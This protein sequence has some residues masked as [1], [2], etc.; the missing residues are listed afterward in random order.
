MS[1]TAIAATVFRVDATKVGISN[2]PAIY[3]EHIPKCPMVCLDD[4]GQFAFYYEHDEYRFFNRPD[5][6]PCMT[7]D[8]YLVVAEAMTFVLGFD[9][10]PVFPSDL[11]SELFSISTNHVYS[12]V[13]HIAASLLAYEI[14]DHPTE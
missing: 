7:Y 2:L 5:I 4:D 8:D 6:Q 10:V 13:V 14:L 11:A 9:D 1:S 3:N 12:K